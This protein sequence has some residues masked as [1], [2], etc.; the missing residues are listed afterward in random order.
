MSNTPGTPE[1]QDSLT[2][3]VTVIRAQIETTTHHTQCMTQI[4]EKMALILDELRNGIKFRE[5]LYLI[6][7][8]FL[9]VAVVAFAGIKLQMPAVQLWG[10]LRLFFLGS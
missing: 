3:L 6:A 2:D 7:I 9:I 4:N 1:Y 5:R 8:L 10:P